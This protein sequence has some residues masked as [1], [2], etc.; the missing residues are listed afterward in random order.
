MTLT[1]FL[2]T[3]EMLLKQSNATEQTYRSALEALLNSALPDCRATNEPKRTRY[4]APDFVMH[5]GN[6][7]VGHVETKDIGVDLDKA[8]ADSERDIPRTQNGKQLKR[9]RAAFPNLLYTDGLVWYWFVAGKPRSPI[10]IA[11]WDKSEQHLHPSPTAERDFTTLLHQFAAHHVM[12]TSTPT[13]LAQRLARIARWLDETIN[14]IL[15]QEEPCGPL[16]E[17]LEAFR[18][19]LLP[20]LSPTDFAGM[21]AQTIVYGVFAAR[22]VDPNRPSFSRIEASQAIPKS[23]PF[24]RKVFQHIAG[25]DLDERIAWLVDDC[26][27]LLEQTDLSEVLRDFGKATRQEDPVVHFYETFLAAYDPKL[28]E[29]RGV[30]YTPEPVVGYLVR[31]I[32]WLLQ[33]HFGKPMGLTDGEV[34]ILDPATGTATFLHAVIQHIYATLSAMG[35]ADTWNRYVPEKLLPRLYGFELL[36]A[37]YTIAHLKLG[38]LLHQLGYRLGDNERLG[39]Y[40]TNAL[41]DAPTG[42]YPLA[43]A[44]FIA[45]EGRAAEEVKHQKPVMVVLGN[46]PYSY[47][48]ANAGKWIGELVRDYYQVEGKPLGERNPKGLQDDYVKFIRMGQWR[49]HQTGEGI[50]AF[51]SNNGYL[52]NITFRGMR[53][54]LLHEFDTI[55]LLNLHGNSRKKERAP[56]GSPDENVFDIQ[57]GVTIGI[58]VKRRTSEG[59][60]IVYYADVWGRR[61]QKFALLSTQDISTIQWQV[62]KPI[63]PMYLFVPHDTTLLMEYHQGWRVTDMLPVNSMGIVTSR[64]RL[65]IQYTEQEMLQVLRDFVSLPPEEAREQYALGE[66]VRDWKVVSAQDDIRKTGITERNIIPIL[67]RPFDRRFTYYT[68]RDRGFHCRPRTGVMQ[69]MVGNH[70]LAL[71]VG[72]A[73]LA[74][75]NQ[76]DWSIVFCSEHVTDCNLYRRGGNNLFPL[77]LYPDGNAHWSLFEHH[78]TRRPNFSSAFT[79]HVEQHLGLQ[80]IPDGRGDLIATVGPEDIFHAVYAILHSPTYRTRYAE[81]LRRDFPHVPIPSDLAVFA[82]LAAKGAAL[83]DLHLVRLPGRGGVGGRGGA[84]ILV[85]PGEQGITQQGVTTTPI[86]QVSYDAQRGR[87]F[88]APECFFAGIEPELWEM[89]IGGYFPLQKWLSDRKDRTLSFDDA[90]HYMRIALAL[91]ET[92]RLM[93]EI[94]EVWYS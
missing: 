31:S 58:F 50:L 29:L 66:D 2:A 30:Y 28:R 86:A 8:I 83:V 43:F 90:L 82:A 56:D 32:D 5:R 54:S 51:V 10:R 16:H 78:N 35:M 61:E 4:G 84:A 24:L 89:P 38:M 36:M 88:I 17:Q 42:Q 13:D 77:Y 59:L 23:N 73:G 11:S 53:E 20:D 34:V 21:Y 94:D 19:T 75:G 1:T 93:G 81:F 72:R 65:T 37:P 71:A 80:F 63:P 67:Y 79:R 44:Q 7:I 68:G 15:T 25:Y 26:A 47:Q 76:G 70:N 62:L 52:D 74:I 41:S 87:V 18:R 33:T 91:R 9:Y 64:D 85:K 92:R 55:Y 49:I 22:M 6:I 60:P 45:A 3:I 57:Q 27:Q 46:P 14:L 12:L 48:S 39:I 40:L 69:H